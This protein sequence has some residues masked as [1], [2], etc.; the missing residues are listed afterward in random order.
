[1]EIVRY[2]RLKE[3]L[4]KLKGTICPTCGEKSISSGLCH[5][6][7]KETQTVSIDSVPVFEDENSVFISRK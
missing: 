5:C 2:W 1:M 4:Y 7:R 6:N 3:P